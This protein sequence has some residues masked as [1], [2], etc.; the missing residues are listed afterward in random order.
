MW[1]WSGSALLKPKLKCESEM[2]T[3]MR[4]L[5]ECAAESVYHKLQYLG[6]INDQLCWW[7][8]YP[9]VCLTQSMP[10]VLVTK[11][12]PHRKCWNVTQII[13]VSHLP[14]DQIIQE[15]MSDIVEPFQANHPNECFQTRCY[16]VNDRWLCK[17]NLSSTNSAPHALVSSARWTPTSLARYTSTW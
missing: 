16:C 13:E 3:G 5:P 15:C 2:N 6:I 17:Y 1:E 11:F 14:R 12:S 8:R 10:V 4:L 9:R 7:S